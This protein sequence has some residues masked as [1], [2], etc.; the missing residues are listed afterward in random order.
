MGVALEETHFAKELV[1]DFQE[2][3]NHTDGSPLDTREAVQILRIIVKE[4]RWNDDT[5]SWDTVRTEAAKLG[6]TVRP[7]KTA[8]DL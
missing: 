5:W 3:V 8:K 6:Y 4:Q 2:I 7:P 1:S